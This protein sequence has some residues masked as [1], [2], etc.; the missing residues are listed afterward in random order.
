MKGIRNKLEDHIGI[1]IMR[2]VSMCMLVCVIVGE[3]GDG[4]YNIFCVEKL[5]ET[6]N[7][8]NQGFGEKLGQNSQN[9]KVV[10]I[11]YSLKGLLDKG[12]CISHVILCRIYNIR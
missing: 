8:G 10:S 4:V 12:M 2:Y 1:Q 3:R 9:K 6:R 11:F 5:R 7:H